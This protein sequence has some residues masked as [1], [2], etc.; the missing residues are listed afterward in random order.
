VTYPGLRKESRTRVL[1]LLEEE[2][3]VD[4]GWQ[5]SWDFEE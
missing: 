4:G 3:V 5:T 1:L 2:E